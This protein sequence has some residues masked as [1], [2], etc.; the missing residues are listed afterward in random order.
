[1]P[2]VLTATLSAC[3]ENSPVINQQICH[4]MFFANSSRLENIAIVYNFIVINNRG[5]IYG[6]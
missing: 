6:Q 3:F 4:C 1:M 2:S 5:I